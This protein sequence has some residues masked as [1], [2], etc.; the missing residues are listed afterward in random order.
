M[1]KEG[2]A[3]DE[4]QGEDRKGQNGD[5]EPKGLSGKLAENQG[6][7]GN[8]SKIANFVSAPLALSRREH[9]R[10]KRN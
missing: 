6:T 5:A 4:R 2:I 7:N 3:I 10:M 8:I 1:P 9:E